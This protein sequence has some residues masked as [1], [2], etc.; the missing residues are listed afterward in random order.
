MERR[1]AP[2]DYSAIPGDA[3][4]S[5]LMTGSDGT[6]LTAHTGEI[7]ATWSKVTGVTGV[8]KLTS[9]RCKG[10][11]GGVSLYYAS[12]DPTSAEYD[13]EADIYVISS[14]DYPGIG[15]RV[16]TSAET[17]Y[18]VWHDP[19]NEW[20][21]VQ[22][23]SGTQTDLGSYSQALVSGT[24]YHV[25]LE[26]RDATK[27]VFIDGVER[28]SSSDNTI[29]AA[30]KAAIRYFNSDWGF[31]TTG[32]AIDNFLATNPSDNARTGSDA[33]LRGRM[34]RPSRSRCW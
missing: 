30:G 34:R 28:I 14:T 8:I 21:L 24:T 10:D 1:V 25:K 27:K 32:K 33:E 3:F 17:G 6:D 15:G 7:G 20:H 2:S 19:S 29:T 22:M 11:S 23:I 13:V 31:G 4:V 18:F 12:G 26:I 9:N 5:D 16:S